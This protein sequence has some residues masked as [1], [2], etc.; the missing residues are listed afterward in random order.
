MTHE[1]KQW[2]TEVFEPQWV[3]KQ[4]IHIGDAK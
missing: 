1:A 3:Q 4:L 2:D